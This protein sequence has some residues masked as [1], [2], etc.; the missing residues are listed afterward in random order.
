[1]EGGRVRK[2]TPEGVLRNVAGT[3]RQGYS[4]DGGPAVD[5]GFEYPD[6]VAVDAKGNI[7]VADNLGHRI[8]LITPDGKIQ[9]FAGTGTPGYGG[10]AGPASAAKLQSPV[11]IALDAAGNLYI[12]DSGNG[13]VR[14]VTPAGMI[15]TLAGTGRE[16]FTGDNGPA[17]SA[18][19]GQ[20]SGLAVDR[21]GNVYIGDSDNS[22]IRKVTA[23]TGNISTFAGNGAE[24]SAG[25]G[26]PALKAAVQPLNLAMDAA[27]NLLIVEVNR[28]RRVTA[29]G[30]IRTI[31]GNGAAG[32][33]GDGSQA[34]SA[35]LRGP[36]AVAVD[37]KANLFIAD[38]LNGRI[39]KV[40]ATG[41]IETIAGSTP[42]PPPS[43]ML[44]MNQGTRGLPPGINVNVNFG[45]PVINVPPPPPVT[46]A[47]SGRPMLLETRLG[48]IPHPPLTTVKDCGHVP[49]EGAQTAVTCVEEA[50]KTKAPFFASFE[51]KGIDSQ[52]VIGL[53]GT[54]PEVVQ[55]L[56][57]SNSGAGARGNP[58]V[59]APRDCAEP[60][61]T[62]ASGAVQVVC[63]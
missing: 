47:P 54:A 10:D 26:G 60:K 57:D 37:A 31:A 35:L 9:T 59:S 53:G 45:N 7:Y 33:S 18:S 23:A 61:L 1:V 21:A 6:D 48:M 39:R 19:I 2:L 4:G 11:R 52:V 25:D 27:G 32:F 63:K 28:I 24:S 55:V 51:Q 3:G 40:S 20:I 38:T 16:G 36:S 41:V 49:K 22:R 62:V 34:A 50:M 13:R 44:S 56:F 30:V 17:N 14:K 12:G 8:R 29:D 5:A 15:S 43:S 58:R 46:V 42:P